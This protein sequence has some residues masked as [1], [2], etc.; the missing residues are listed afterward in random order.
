MHCAMAHGVGLYATIRRS[1]FYVFFYLKI[2]GGIS[3]AILHAKY[4]ERLRVNGKQIL[5]FIICVLKFGVNVCKTKH[6][7]NGHLFSREFTIR[8]Y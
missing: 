3:A 8:V 1:M 6:C 4:G 2:Y 5:K 7:K